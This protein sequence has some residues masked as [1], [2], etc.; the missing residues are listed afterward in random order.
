[1]ATI[2]RK[3][4]FGAVLSRL[5]GEYSGTK[6]KCNKLQIEN[7]D[8]T[9]SISFFK[10]LKGKEMKLFIFC[11][12]RKNLAQLVH[13]CEIADLGENP[14]NG[15]YECDHFTCELKCPHGFY[16]NGGTGRKI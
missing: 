15:T 12:L 13:Q 1:M 7:L 8:F 16:P 4:Y 2:Y 14:N 11:L 10:K 6:N 5:T 3:K 9:F